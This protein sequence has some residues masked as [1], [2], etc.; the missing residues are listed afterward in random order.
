MKPL[1]L[2][3]LLVSSFVFAD[4]GMWM[5]QQMPEL[6]KELKELGLKIDPQDLTELTGFPMGAI[7][8][9]GGCTA[10]FVSEI[11]L[12]VT[13]HHCA[14]GV[15]Q[16]N[17]TP[18]NNLLENGFYAKNLTDEIPAGPGSRIYVT[19]EV[20]NVT[21]QVMAAVPSEAKGKVYLDAIDSQ[22]KKMIA[23]GEASGPFRCSV[24]RFYGGKE[25]YFI[26]KL[27]IKDVRL[28]YAPPGG[29]GKFGGDIDN[30]M[31]PRH[32][33]DFAFYRAYVG[34]DG[35]PAEFSE[36]NVPFEPKHYLKVAK[37]PLN[38]G[39]YVMVAGYPG[40]TNRHARASEVAFQFETS[41]PQRIQIFKDI[42]EIIANETK[43]NPQ[44]ALKYAATTSYINNGLKNNQGMLEGFEK[45]GFMQVKQER[46]QKLLNWIQEDSGR[47]KR[48]EPAILE[49]EQLLS[50]EYQLK[51]ASS[52]LTLAKRLGVFGSAVTLHRLSVEKEKPD[53]ER[54][55]KFQARDFGRIKMGLKRMART[56]DPNVDQAL[57]KYFIE[58]YA[59]LPAETRMAEF[60]QWFGIGKV[61][62]LDNHLD[63]VLNDM[64]EKTTLTSTEKRLAWSEASR[65]EIEA[66]EDPFLQLAVKLFPSSLK[67]EHEKKERLGRITP[68]RK[69][70]MEALVAFNSEQGYNVY[71]DAN[72]SLRITFGTVKGYQPKDGVFHTPFTSLKG[73]L[74]KDTGVDPF[75]SPQRVLEAIRNKST[76]NYVHEPIN[77]V[78]VNYLSTV[79][80]TGGNSGSPTLNGSGELIGLLFDGNYESMTSDWLFNTELTRS[81]H[82][83]VRY[84]LWLMDEVDHAD[85]LLEEMGVKKPKTQKMM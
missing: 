68:L 48:F 83:D 30:W 13:N 27:E 6:E 10:S 45:T 55:L 41:Y 57:L 37:E 70:Y 46:E 15:I 33:G 61:D 36:E 14:Y 31:W 63:K 49:L 50:E 2:I 77:C 24:D 51:Q 1:S 72:G 18:E 65:K 34:P 76:S 75:N 16:Y 4:E 84:I 69:A 40:R 78:P 43:G 5:P 59:K 9:L 20:K 11:G 62:D 79:D 67:L 23:E 58:K 74:E 8:S 12:A 44:A 54:E 17:S 38:E 66:S 21:D 85:R 56:M 22:I 28:V 81:I 53:S 64:Y 73:I 60:D 26:K 3:L 82:V 25:F 35:Q 47:A 71:P 7:I 52:L 19:V 32:T 80:T 42:L 29:V 39:D